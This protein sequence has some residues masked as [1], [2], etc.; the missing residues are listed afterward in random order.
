MDEF[1]IVDPVE[2]VKL[3]KDDIDKNTQGSCTFGFHILNR[4]SHILH[5][6]IIGDIGWVRRTCLT[7]RIMVIREGT[8]FYR[9]TE[10]QHYFGCPYQLSSKGGDKPDDGV[11]RSIHLQAGDIVVCGSDG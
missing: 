1:G 5:T 6:L 11:I 10:Q 3:V 9:S 2:C 7:S 4:Y 8:I